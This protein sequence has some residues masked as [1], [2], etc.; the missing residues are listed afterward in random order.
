MCIIEGLARIENKH[1]IANRALGCLL[2]ISNVTPDIQNQITMEEA[3]LCWL[4]NKTRARYILRNLL[5]KSNENQRLHAAALKLY[6]TW[7]IETCSE[8]PKT[9][10]SDYFLKSL[11]ILTNLKRTTADCKNIY[12]TYNVLAR[13]ADL[14]YQQVI[15]ELYSQLTV[16]TKTTF[17]GS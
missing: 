14:Q 5:S 2:H 10:I 11:D 7:M 4:D 8:N 12:E 6:G 17:L 9:I 13:F 15:Q 16:K 3:Q 1:N